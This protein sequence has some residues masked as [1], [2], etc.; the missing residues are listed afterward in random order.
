MRLATIAISAVIAALSTQ[1]SLSFQ[2]FSVRKQFLGYHHTQQAHSSSSPTSISTLYATTKDQGDSSEEAAIGSGD[3][4]KK[5]FVNPILEPL[6]PFLPA[7]DPKYAVTGPV[8]EGDFVITREG[9]PTKE[10]LSNENLLSILMV[11]CSDLEV[12]TLVWKCLGYRFDS[13]KQEWTADECFPNWKANFPTPPDLIGMSRIFSK[14]VDQPS[15]K[16]NQAIV[17]SIPAENK[18]SLKVHLKPYGFTGYQYAELT[19][20][21]T[22]RAQCANWLLFYRE[23]LFGYTVE[24]LREKRRLKKEAEEAEKRRI[25]LETGEA[26]EE[27]WKPPVKEVF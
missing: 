19:P 8:G 21:K 24:E 16:A 22:R 9:G 7:T 20:N 12:N 14:E 11:E 27:G 1:Q 17:R 15:L 18:Q 2:P 13:S 26:P 23:E 25:E 4:P 6:Q 5:T 10:E 3:K